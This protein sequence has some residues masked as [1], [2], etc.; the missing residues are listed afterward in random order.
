MFIIRRL[1]F[2]T[3]M[4]SE[5]D[6]N[7]R[8]MKEFDLK[9]PPPTRFLTRESPYFPLFTLEKKL[10]EMKNRRNNYP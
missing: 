10:T 6:S 9:I 8:D 1:S 7:K 2:H 5:R 4:R 3:H